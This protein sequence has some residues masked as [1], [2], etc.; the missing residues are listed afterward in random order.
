MGGLGAPS[1]LEATVGF[2]PGTLGDRGLFCF[3]LVL[4]VLFETESY[5]VSL[6]S[7]KLSLRLGLNSERATSLVFGVQD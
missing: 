1:I 3:V 5:Y 2:L 7:L 6:A 4:F